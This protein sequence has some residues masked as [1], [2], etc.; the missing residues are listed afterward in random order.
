MMG[1][2]SN[3]Q[4]NY[5]LSSLKGLYLVGGIGALSN[6]TID[7]NNKMPS[8]F[9]TSRDKIE[10]TASGT[11]LNYKK[12]NFLGQVGIGYTKNHFG[13]ELYYRPTHNTLRNSG[14]IDLNQKWTHQAGINGLYYF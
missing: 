2:R 12:L 6:W 10:D 14:L 9:Q 13:V 8:N 4:I 1:I 3:G 5:N 11:Q 7:A